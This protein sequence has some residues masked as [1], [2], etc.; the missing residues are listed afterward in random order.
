MSIH[1]SGIFAEIYEGDLNGGK[2]ERKGR[3][4]TWGG[5]AGVFGGFFVVGMGVLNIFDWKGDWVM[6]EMRKACFGVRTDLALEER[7]RFPG[8]GGEVAGVRLREWEKEK[9]GLRLT[10]VVITNEKGARSMGKPVGTYLTLEAPGLAKKD[11]DYHKEVV[12]ELSV[13][14]RSL[15]GRHGI[16]TKEGKAP[17]VLVVG[18]GN[19]E[20]TP[21]SLGPRV[22]ENLQM[23][24]QLTFEYGADFCA[25]HGYPV[26]SGITP[27]VMAQT[28]METAEIIR[29]IVKE[30]KP[31]AVLAI[32]ALAARSVHRLGV[33]IQLSDT[34]IH[35]GSGVGNHR[36]SLTE[37]TLGAPVFALGVP[38]V[39]GAA[40]I[41]HDTVGAMTEVLKREKATAGFGTAIDQMEPEEQYELIR[42]LLEPQFGPMY[43][44]PHNIDEQVRMLSFLISEA[45]HGA[46]VS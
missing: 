43:V 33:T 12:G 26:L 9:A 4:E 21:D 25:G 40:A 13:Q 7:E 37:E 5:A 1:I 38:T 34:G 11:E 39:V 23:T 6:E 16:G 28:G 32:D 17:A 18:L 24:R 22:L 35:P 15:F 45:I 36:N 19:M 30:T 10:E 42:E 2:R 41:V 31:E 8:D 29:G 46:L 3:K 20:A 44:T 27:G 14:L